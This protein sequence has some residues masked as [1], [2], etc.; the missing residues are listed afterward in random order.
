MT[1]V[2][3]W[4]AGSGLVFSGACLLC[5]ATAGAQTLAQDAGVGRINLGGRGLGNPEA[6]RT[7]AASEVEPPEFSAKAGIA[8]DYIYRGTTLSDRKPAVGAGV[9][10][11]FAGFYAGATAATVKLPTQPAGEYTVSAGAR[12]SFGKFDFDLGVTYFAY[13]SEIPGGPTDGIEYYEAAFRTDVQL[14]ERWRAAGGFAYSPNVSN[15]GAWSWYAAAGLGYE[16]PAGALPLNVAIVLTAAAGYSW[17]GPQ[18]A[19][20]GGFELPAYLN[21]QVGATLTHKFLN[22]DLRYY[23]TNLSRENCYVFTGDPGAQPGGR[24]NPVSNPDGLVSRWC[25]AALV[26]KLW[27]AIN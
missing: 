21:W 10:A 16:V 26:A 13:P 6:P 17:F 24:A 12:R 25:S 9:E 19:A 8:S 7:P 14:A 5:A 23:D 11:S 15:T 4:R 2:R 3:S 18:S 20:L 27:F 22:V 1:A